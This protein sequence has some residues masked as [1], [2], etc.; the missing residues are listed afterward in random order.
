MFWEFDSGIRDLAQANL[1]RSCDSL[2]GGDFCSRYRNDFTHEISAIRVISRWQRSEVA[3]CLRSRVLSRASEL[4]SSLPLEFA[5]PIRLGSVHEVELRSTLQD[6]W[7]EDQVPWLSWQPALILPLLF[8][9]YCPP[10]LVYPLLPCL[11]LSLIVVLPPDPFSCS[12]HRSL[13]IL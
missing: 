4:A 7:K 1:T 10:L 11:R 3:H 9:R 8:Y 2:H 13:L 12:L 6:G 5:V